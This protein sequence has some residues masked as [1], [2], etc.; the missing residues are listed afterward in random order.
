MAPPDRG[1]SGASARA[2]KTYML[3]ILY[4]RTAITESY[5]GTGVCGGWS[6]SSLEEMMISSFSN[7]LVV[8]EIEGLGERRWRR[9]DPDPEGD[10]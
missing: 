3:L 1:R 4:I 2:S 6:F 9:Q 5:E 8:V 7:E 10:P